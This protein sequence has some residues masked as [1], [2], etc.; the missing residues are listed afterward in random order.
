MVVCHKMNEYVPQ[1]RVNL[2]N[3]A[4]PV[5]SRLLC[6]WHCSSSAWLKPVWP[7]VEDL[8]TADM[9]RRMVTFARLCCDRSFARHVSDIMSTCGPIKLVRVGALI[10]VWEQSR[11]LSGKVCTQRYGG[12]RWVDLRS[13]HGK[14][15]VGG[16]GESIK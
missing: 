16:V 9:A 5:W 12:R 13:P 4:I 8:G 14:P 6:S 3:F 10:L 7:T 1:I 11:L 2:C 15:E